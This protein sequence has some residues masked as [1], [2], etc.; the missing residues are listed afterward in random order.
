MFLDELQVAQLE[1]SEP[2]VCT[3]AARGPVCPRQSRGQSVL[4]IET[5]GAGGTGFAAKVSLLFLP[6][7]TF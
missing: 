7:S 2:E 3:Q 4:G 6:F 1:K 5:V